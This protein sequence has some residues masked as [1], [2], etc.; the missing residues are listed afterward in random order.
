MKIKYINNYNNPV[1]LIDFTLG[2][3]WS[4]INYQSVMPSGVSNTSGG[5]KLLVASCQFRIL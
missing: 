5:S 3:F 2:L 4:N 1:P